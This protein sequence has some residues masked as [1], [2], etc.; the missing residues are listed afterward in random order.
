MPDD[1]AKNR[2]PAQHDP[3]PAFGGEIGRVGR[4]AELS[5]IEDMPTKYE[6]G[7]AADT[8]NRGYIG[9]TVS[10]RRLA[11][12]FAI[13]AVCLVIVVLRIVQV[14]II[15]HDYYR[16]QAEGNRTRA[17]WIPSERGIIYDRNG[18]PLVQN[19]PNF[20][21]VLRPAE[22]PTGT[23]RGELISRVA[24]IIG[25]TPNEIEQMVSSTKETAES[26]VIGEHLNHDQAVLLI[27]EGADSG[28]V[29]LE[30][31]TRRD[32]LA[33]KDIRS[34]S[35]VIG[36]EGRPTENEMKSTTD[37]YLASDLVGKTGLEKYYESTLRGRYGK[38]VMEIDALGRAKKVISEESGTAGQNLV[39]SIDLNIQRM[40]ENL[41]SE[42]LRAIGKTRGS[43]IVLEPDTGEIL[44]MVSEPD[45]DNNL[46]AQGISSEDFR[47]LAEDRD[48]PMFPRAIAAALPSGSVF[49]MV[50][51]SAALEEGLITAN[52]TILSTGGIRVDKWFFPDWKTGGHGPTNVTKALAESVNTFFYAI[53]GGWD[54]I[55]GL[56]IDRIIAYAKKFGM[57]DRLGVDLAG[58]GSGFLPS[59][60]WKEE[61]KGENWYV[62][63][64]YHLAIGQ[65]DILVT[66]LQIASMTAVFANGGKLIRPRLVNA[67]TSTDGSRTVREPQTVNAQ[68]V[69][70][71]NIAIVRRGMRQAVISGS[72]TSLAAVP[73]AVAA[74][75][76]TAQWSNSRPPHA[77]FT[78]FA[79]YNDPKLV[80]TVVIE[81]GGEGSQTAAPVA[82]RFLSWYFGQRE[83]QP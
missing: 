21:L 49:K 22:L 64:T 39:L 24:E 41:L 54:K 32:Y 65:G 37:H 61:T 53:G 30:V 66:P 26:V 58:E 18:T 7:G 29:S 28:A 4:P 2:H 9:L 19:V 79:P 80:V 6:A 67:L 47:R 55:T 12:F 68:V 17:I 52:T 3:F 35:H 81:D 63:D 1:Q 44:A 72:A 50:V 27:I 73:V 31:G 33:T 10:D 74:K 60:Q 8:E 38:R 40:A 76:G 14:Q 43:I 75:T 23:A 77:W 51:A 36:F 59:K 82:R 71:E 5:A 34:M 62:G 20:T 56:G 57:G 83:S 48:N 69:S 15:H 46:F 11:V 13:L 16:Q 70:P 78:S 42:Q 45:F 25:M